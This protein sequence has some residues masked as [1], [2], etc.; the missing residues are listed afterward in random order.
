MALDI[1]QPVCFHINFRIN[2][3]I[4]TTKNLCD[5]SRLHWLYRSINVAHLS[6]LLC[7]AFF[8][9]LLCRAQSRDLTYFLKYLSSVVIVSCFSMSTQFY[10]W[11]VCHQYTGKKKPMSCKLILHVLNLWNPFMSSSWFLMNSLGFSTCMIIL[12]MNGDNF[13]FSIPLCACCPSITIQ[14][15]ALDL[16][17][18]IE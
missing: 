2:L 16:R 6:I 11:I 1:L 4:S 13:N 10:S 12:A 3:P 7:L 14:C 15:T 18:N 17:I 5:S 8:L 9:V